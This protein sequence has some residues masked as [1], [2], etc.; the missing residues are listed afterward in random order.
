MFDDARGTICYP[1]IR[2]WLLL[3]VVN[4]IIIK[5]VYRLSPDAVTSVVDRDVSTGSL[6][7]GMSSTGYA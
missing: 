6:H 1:V 5:S 3:M 4:T 7:H 2:K